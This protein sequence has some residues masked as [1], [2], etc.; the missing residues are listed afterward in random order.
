MAFQLAKDF[1]QLFSGINKDELQSIT[2]GDDF[3]RELLDFMMER[4]YLNL[5]PERE[6]YIDDKLNKSKVTWLRVMRL[7]INPSNNENYDLISRWQGVLSTLH[8]WGH[9]IVFL[10]QW[11]ASIRQAL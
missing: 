6:R 4:S 1:G 5:L 10:L 3:Y 7:P 9:K 8:T 2:V 11:M